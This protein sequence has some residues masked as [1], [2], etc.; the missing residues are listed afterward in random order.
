VDGRGLARTRWT[1]P[2]VN[3]TPKEREKNVRGAFAVGENRG[4]GRFGLATGI[5]QRPGQSPY[6]D[7]SVLLVDD[8]YTTGATAREC[9]RVLADA[10]ARRVGVL[11]AARVV[12]K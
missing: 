9:A 6:E 8:V 10:G 4:S 5:A 12:V 11:T 7:A 2:Q 1:E 3:L